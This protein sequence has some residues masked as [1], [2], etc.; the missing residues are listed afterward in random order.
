MKRLLT[1]K[2]YKHNYSKEY[3]V[4]SKNIKMGDEML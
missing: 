1:T 3:K 2:N 4:Y